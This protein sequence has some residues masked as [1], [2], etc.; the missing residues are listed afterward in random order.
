MVGQINN[1]PM[2]IYRVSILVLLSV[3]VLACSSTKEV[4][5]QDVEAIITESADQSISDLE[6]VTPIISEDVTAEEFKTLIEK[7]EGVI[8]DVR[9]KDEVAGGKIGDAINLDYYSDT[10]KNDIDKLD[11]NR[12]VY[13]YCR[14]GSRSGGAKKIMTS[15]GFKA[16]YN[17]KGGYSNWPYK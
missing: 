14:S 8:L 7:K 11:K 1:R 10:F 15:M 3:F 5:K 2:K 6:E 16:V 12:P 17:L 13:V 4:V 9:T